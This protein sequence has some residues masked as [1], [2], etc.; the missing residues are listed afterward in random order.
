MVPL[1]RCAGEENRWRRGDSSPVKRGRGTVGRSPMVEGATGR[2]RPQ[3]AGGIGFRALE[4]FGLEQPATHVP[5]VAAQSS[6]PELAS[7]M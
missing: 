1:P 5:Q 6:E 2:S 7:H 4:M 3:F